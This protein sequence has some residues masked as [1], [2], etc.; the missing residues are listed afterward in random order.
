V[1]E[2]SKT[3]LKLNK[4]KVLINREPK[5]IQD[6]KL[7]ERSINESNVDSTRRDND[8]N[9]KIK[10]MMWPFVKTPYAVNNFDNRFKAQEKMLHDQQRMIK[11]IYYLP[12]DPIISAPVCIVFFYCFLWTFIVSIVVF[13]LSIRYTMCKILEHFLDVF[14]EKSLK[15]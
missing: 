1:K 9:K 15:I 8:L 4:R 2:N 3:N 7:S 11:G 12:E 5:D 13:G 6:S 10:D 14:E